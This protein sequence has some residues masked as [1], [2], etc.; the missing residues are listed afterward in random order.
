MA[1]SCRLTVS[2]RTLCRTNGHRITPPVLEQVKALEE[3]PR[4]LVDGL[5]TS[6]DSSRFELALPRSGTK[7]IKYWL[8]IDDEMQEG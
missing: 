8:D 3:L 6:C 2:G 7:L 5:C 1:Q 4:R